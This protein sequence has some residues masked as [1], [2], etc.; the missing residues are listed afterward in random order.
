[1][2][3]DKKPPRG[4]GV[5]A[6]RT[7]DMIAPEALENLASKLK[8]DLSKPTA[9]PKPAAAREKGTTRNQTGPE[10]QRE[11]K[12]KSPKK[13]KGKNKPKAEGANVAN[14]HSGNGQSKS[15]ASPKG[16]KIVEKKQSLTTQLSNGPGKSA[17]IIEKKSTTFRGKDHKRRVSTSLLDEILALG[18]TKE[19]LELVEGVDSDD[20]LVVDDR[21]PKKGKGDED[22]V[23]FFPKPFFLML[24]TSRT[25]EAD[26]R[27]GVGR[28]I[29]GGIR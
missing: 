22:S 9:N 26:E 2:K 7:V 11:V 18:G 17:S 8:A 16:L 5:E 23:V 15:L 10:K 14:G 24:V 4:N 27:A 20:D 1:M 3:K 12:N 6:S 28:E 29:S 21:E 25:T 13:D 19:D